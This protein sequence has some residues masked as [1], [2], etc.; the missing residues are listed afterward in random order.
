V[1]GRKTVC[2]LQ[3]K[4]G[5]ASCTLSARQLRR[6]TYQLQAR[7][8]GSSAFRPATSPAIRLRVTG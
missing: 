3:L 5:R 6:G 2:A 4:A 1:A 8:S 7:Y